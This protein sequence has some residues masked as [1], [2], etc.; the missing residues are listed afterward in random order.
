MILTFG[1]REEKNQSCDI[2]KIGVR[3]QED[4]SVEMRLL[5]VP[6]ICTRVVD[7]PV[8]WCRREY[9]HLRELNLSDMS[10]GEEPAMLIGSDYYWQFVTGETISGSNGPVAVHT[11]FGWVISGPIT[12]E[13]N[14]QMNA[15]LITHVLRVDTAPSLKSLDKQLTA[16]WELESFGVTDN[17]TSVHEQFDSKI[18]MCDGRYEVPLPWK[19][20]YISLP[21]NLSLARRRLRSLLRRLKQT[22]EVFKEYHRIIR[23]Q[24]E[25]GII[26]EVKEDVADD[27]LHYLPHHAVIKRD[28]ETSKVRVVYDASAR[29]NGL[30][31]NDCL[32]KGPKFNQKIFNILL[33]FRTHKIALTADIEK[34]FL[35]ISIVLRDRNAL[36]FLWI[37]DPSDLDNIQTYRFTRVVFGV[38]SSPFLLNATIKHHLERYRHTNEDFVDKLMKCFYVDD[39]IT[40]AETVQ[41]AL[42]LFMFS[43][44]LMKEGGFNLCKFNSNS[45]QLQAM[46]DNSNDVIS[47]NPSNEETYVKATLGKNFETSKNEKKILGI[48]WNVKLDQ[49][50]FE[51]NNV[52]LAAKELEP[53]KRH[54]VSLSGRFYDPLGFITPVTVQYKVLIQELCRAGVTWDETLQG[55][56]LKRWQSLVQGL[57]DCHPII[58]PRY[59]ALTVDSVH[60][61]QLHGFS[62]ASNVAYAAVVFLLIKSSSNSKA[63]FVASKSRV[64]PLQQQTIPRLELLGALLLARLITTISDN[65]KPEMTLDSPVCYTD[66]QIALCWIRGLDKEWKPFIQ[67][68]VS[69]I[70]RLV[71]IGNWKFCPGKENPADIPSRGAPPTELRDNSL[72]WNGPSWLGNEVEDLQ[73]DEM[74]TEC[75]L[76][77]KL[78]CNIVELLIKEK[79]SI[80][81]IMEIENYS[82]LNQLLFITAQVLKAVKRFR[83]EN[84]TY[85]R[86]EFLSTAENMWLLEVQS[87]LTNRTDFSVLKRQL[88]LYCDEKGIWRCGGRLEQSNLPYSTKHPIVLPK[89]HYFSSLVIRQAHNRVGHNGTKETLTEV[90]SKY[91]ILRGRT[92]IKGFIAKCNICR[93]FEGAAYKAPPPPPLPSFRVTEHPPFTYTGVDYAGPLMV[94]P[95]HPVKALCTQ[96]VWICLYTCC[97]TRA[98]HIDLVPNLTCQSFLRSF[99]RFTSR[100]GLPHKM[101]S[102]NGTTFKSAA[103]LIKKIVKNDAV[104]EY[105]SGLKISWTFNIERAPWW[106]GVFERMIGL[107]KRCLRKVVGRSRLSYDELLTVVTEIE[108]ILNSR[109]ISYVSSSDLEEPLTPSHLITGR[110]LLNLPDEICYRHIEEE[111]NPDNSTLILNRRMKYLHST[112]DKFW[113]R[114]RN[115]YLLNLRE[116]YYI[117][118][119]SLSHKA[120]KIGDVVIIHSDDLA[121]GFWKIGKVKEIIPGKDGEVRG[122]IVQVLNG[123]KRLSLMRRPI[124]RLIPLE[125]SMEKES[126][127]LPTFCDNEESRGEDSHEEEVVPVRID[128]SNI[129]PAG[130]NRPKRAAAVQA[131]DGIIASLCED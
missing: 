5:S 105:L 91:W 98:V 25:S 38:S 64:A 52:F 81:N 103:K 39:V 49:F 2:V 45:Q 77:L 46:I 54:I 37:K 16:F 53:T 89:D 119:R 99:K 26:E 20:S 8:E 41:E 62:D 19:D 32:Y 102:D 97:V 34:A 79:Y 33:K 66:S 7:V 75:N 14:Q 84:T 106:G 13:L 71:S 93:R 114:W 109:P 43:K 42:S 92:L 59:Y 6:I 28:R 74:P 48:I 116:R 23:Q 112:L 121:R 80:S 104:S 107:T 35:M 65:F 76:E 1:S 40:G 117:R 85:D 10:R 24:L 127:E 122:G 124:Q 18:T 110:R 29:D 126:V 47:V 68:R 56:L 113:N 115:E 31:L 78:S 83:K 100:R 27:R 95:D 118:K 88:D 111:F 90:R 72:W 63:I 3:T 4:S 73:C 60:T 58:I 128:T 70:R 51:F 87:N 131:R 15:N 57:R 55:D 86:M 108:S 22:P 67:N 129:S 30:S 96:K 69:E 11:K 125:T 123:N 120:I 101:I 44:S 50:I 9:E 17:E 82:K 12:V 94:R 130:N 21:D 36:R 61:Y